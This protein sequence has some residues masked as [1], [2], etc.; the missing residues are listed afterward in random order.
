IGALSVGERR[1]LEFVRKH[2]V[3][4]FRAIVQEL[5]AYSERR[6]RAAIAQIPDG[7]YVAD[8]YIIDNDGWLDEPARVRVEVRV[9]GDDVVADFTGTEP[10][11]RGSCNCTLVATVSAVFNAILHITDSDIPAN[12]GRYRPIRVVAPEG[13]LVNATFPVAT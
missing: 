4:Q 12:A 7:R 5:K 13:T 2:G 9:E 11:R 8:E 3:E 6:M 10:Q 1:L